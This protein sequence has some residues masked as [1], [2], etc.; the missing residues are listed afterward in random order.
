MREAVAVMGRVLLFMVETIGVFMCAFII[1]LVAR[2][3]VNELVKGLKQKKRT[4]EV[5]ALM[6]D[7][8][9]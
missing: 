2:T 3:F 5:K 7:E 6:K 1:L 8:K 9:R 4:K